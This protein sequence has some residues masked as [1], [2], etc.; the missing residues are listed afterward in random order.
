MLSERIRCLFRDGNIVVECWFVDWDYSSSTIRKLHCAFDK[1]A[2]CPSS[3][4]KVSQS[5]WLVAPQ[6]P[7]PAKQTH[8]RCFNRLTKSDKVVGDFGFYLQHICHQCM[9]FRASLLHDVKC[10]LGAPSALRRH[11]NWL[12]NSGDHAM[13]RMDTGARV[14]SFQGVTPRSMNNIWNFQDLES[15]M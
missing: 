5:K 13:S 3:W 2:C 12:T 15:K 14:F 6:R 11:V 8:A 7:A 9:Y 4:V 1:H 10:T